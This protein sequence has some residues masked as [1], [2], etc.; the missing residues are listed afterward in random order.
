MVKSI[1]VQYTPTLYYSSANRLE[2]Y[3]LLH[4][5]NGSW[6]TRLYEL[7][8]MYSETRAQII[9]II[10]KV[11]KLTGAQ[12]TGHTE[13]D[14]NT[15]LSTTLDQLAYK[16]R[17]FES[18]EKSCFYLDYNI[19]L[20]SQNFIS[21]MAYDIVRNLK[22]REPFIFG[23]I[24]QLQQIDVSSVSLMTSNDTDIYGLYDD[25]RTVISA[26]NESI[27]YFHE[28]YEIL[29]GE[30]RTNRKMGSYNP[31]LDGSSEEYVR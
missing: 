24:N 25:I 11:A 13:R 26:V 29:A 21:R 19:T 1:S 14:Q 28:E 23:Y 22:N 10:T 18:W 9:K 15:C 2:D 5:V 12:G 31:P 16:L 7:S 4:V 6:T 3:T 20:Y 27:A 17:Q 30:I 8:K